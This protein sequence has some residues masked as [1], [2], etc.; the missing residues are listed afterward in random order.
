MTD[1]EVIAMAKAIRRELA[2][3]SVAAATLDS[4]LARAGTGET[5]ADELLLAMAAGPG[6]RAALRRLLPM[7][8]DPE[9]GAAAPYASLAGFGD[10][11]A[12]ELYTCLACHYS[13]PV[14]EAGEPVP[15]CPRGHGP[16]TAMVDSA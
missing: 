12:E 6:T 13:Y 5:V 7:E 16:L 1:D 15:D 8:A 9:R 14:F 11:S 2:D 3:D 4:L 10:P